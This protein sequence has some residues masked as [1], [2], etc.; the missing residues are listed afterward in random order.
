[1][2]KCR[3]FVPKLE[4]DNGDFKCEE[5]GFIVALCQSE[6]TRFTY[7]IDFTIGFRCLVGKTPVQRLSRVWPRTPIGPY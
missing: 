5:S 1:M 3:L 2:P 6:R 4:V 7:C